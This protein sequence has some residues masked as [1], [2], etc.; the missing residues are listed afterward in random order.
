MNFIVG[1]GWSFEWF[2]DLKFKLTCN[3]KKYNI[4]M[5]TVRIMDGYSTYSLLQQLIHL[6]QSMFILP[7][8]YQLIAYKVID[9][10]P[11]F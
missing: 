7:D 3:Y 5:H 4:T 9:K 6:V 2:I 8:Q 10:C 11:F 1:L